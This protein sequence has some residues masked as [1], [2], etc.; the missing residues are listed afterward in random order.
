MV[1]CAVTELQCM[2]N[3]EDGARAQQLG[4]QPFVLV[5]IYVTI[6]LVAMIAAVMV[7]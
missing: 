3:L 2:S 5:G 6:L 1:V 4:T 7:A